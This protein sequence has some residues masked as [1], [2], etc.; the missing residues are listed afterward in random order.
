MVSGTED[1]KRT[2]STG[3]LQSSEVLGIWKH[4]VA[5][6]AAATSL[7][8]SYLPMC[9]SVGLDLEYLDLLLFSFSPRRS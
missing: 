9:I 5:G 7:V 6:S 3:A 4:L 2:R 8:G 1:C